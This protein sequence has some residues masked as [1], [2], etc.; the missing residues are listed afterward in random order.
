MKLLSVSKVR[1]Y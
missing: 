1:I